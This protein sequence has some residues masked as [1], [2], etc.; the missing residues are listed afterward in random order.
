MTF[1]KGPLPD[2]RPFQQQVTLR[3][4]VSAGP[5]WSTVWKTRRHGDLTALVALHANLSQ[6]IDSVR[7]EFAAAPPCLAVAT[8]NTNVSLGFAVALTDGDGAAVAP[9]DASVINEDAEHRPDLWD[10]NAN[11]CAFPRGAPFRLP[12][13]RADRAE[14]STQ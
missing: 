7:Y 11:S 3:D 5:G 1:N 13:S 10:P 4:C 8:P 6:P 12:G 9:V 14:I 2:Y